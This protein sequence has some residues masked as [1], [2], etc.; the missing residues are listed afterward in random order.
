MC[1]PYQNDVSQKSHH[2]WRGYPYQAIA[3][4]RLDVLKPPPPPIM[5][6]RPFLGPPQLR[7]K[8]TNF[9]IQVDQWH[10]KHCKETVGG[11]G[12]HYE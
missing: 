7:P 2:F 11:F 12:Y 5:T 3:P 9:T 10:A 8:T 1:F 6:C 4:L